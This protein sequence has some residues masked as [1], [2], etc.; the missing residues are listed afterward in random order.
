MNGGSSFSFPKSRR[1][2]IAGKNVRAVVDG[3]E[4]LGGGKGAAQ[5]G[6]GVR[7]REPEPVTRPC[8]VGVGVDAE[9]DVGEALVGVASI[10]LSFRFGD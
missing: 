1:V 3:G 8:C 9:D 6:S 2:T 10:V 7:E 4:R 5:T